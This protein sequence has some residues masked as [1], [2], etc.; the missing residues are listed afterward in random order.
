[1]WWFWLGGIY[2]S[3]IFLHEF[4]RI[5]PWGGFSPTTTTI[6]FQALVL[7]YGCSYSYFFWGLF[8]KF[9][10]TYHHAHCLFHVS[11]DENV[12][13]L[14]QLLLLNHISTAW[15]R[16]SYCGIASYVEPR[17]YFLVI[18]LLLLMADSYSTFA[19]FQFRPWSF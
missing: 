5:I 13:F 10:I 17:Q 2:F 15:K 6:L 18:L 19:C 3:F 7:Y 4:Y 12:V 9:N 14:F 16:N 11:H 1:M 8:Q